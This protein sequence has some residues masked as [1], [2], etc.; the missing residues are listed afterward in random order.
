MDETTVDAHSPRP[1]ETDA[2][3]GSVKEPV[4][5]DANEDDDESDLDLSDLAGASHVDRTVD[6]N[7]HRFADTWRFHGL[8]M[9]SIDFTTMSLSRKNCWAAWT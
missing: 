8:Q 6:S 5:S 4:S 9:S 1:A 7:S 3:T 2:H